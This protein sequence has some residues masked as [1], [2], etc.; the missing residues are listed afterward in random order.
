[1][2]AK[3]NH[4]LPHLA[5]L[6]AL[7]LIAKAPAADDDLRKQVL[8]LN[9][10]TGTEQLA[11]KVKEWLKEK[12]LVEKR[13][14][15]AEEILKSDPKA[16]KYNGAA[17]LARV[18]AGQKNYE[19]SLKLFK[20]CKE[21]AQMLKSSSKI[22]EAFEGQIAVLYQMKQ[23]DEAEKLCQEFLE[24]EGD[25]NLEKVKPF[26]MEQMIELKTRQGKIQDALKMTDGLIKLDEG[27]WYFVRLKGWVLHEAGKNDESAAAYHE[28]LERVEKSERLKGEEQQ[29][30]ADR[31]RYILSN[32]YVDMDKVD[33]AAE[34]LKE[35]IKK[36][37]NNPTYL[38][39]LGYIWAD[40]DQNLDESEKMIRKAL[41]E[42]RKLRK[43]MK[44]LPKEDDVD[45]AAYLDSLGWV[46][47]KKK[48]FPEAKKY[49]LEATKDKDEGQHIEILDHLA[50]VHMALGEKS[51]AAAVW[52]KALEYDA[53][54]KR[55]LK[56]RD[57]VEKKLK[58]AEK[59]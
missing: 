7:V 11:A 53:N 2:N 25:D 17:I 24:A 57:E 34:Q 26:V 3:R 48:Q 55:E 41:D 10:I 15:T 54:T 12:K 43:E 18:A 40:H 35:L 8:Q 44:E 28:A 14:K 31:I 59:Q 6:V 16:I 52:K 45:K 27:G 1:M 32:V 56:K 20:L 38:N 13:L 37:P 39:D 46:L 4:V 30:W 5:M 33:K 19:L 58:S 47:F 51:E 21:Q 22:S 36:H 42:D 29:K 49:L 23:Y 9:S 50:D